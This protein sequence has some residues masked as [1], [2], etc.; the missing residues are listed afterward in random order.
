MTS[1]T[2][3]IAA[4]SGGDVVGWYANEPDRVLVRLWSGELHRISVNALERA[5][6]A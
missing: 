2:E 4:G 5:P 6:A 3:G 1:E